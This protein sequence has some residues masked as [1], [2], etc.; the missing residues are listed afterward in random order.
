MATYKEMYFHLFAMTE[1]A[2]DALLV[3]DYKLAYDVLCTAQQ[4]CEEMYLENDDPL[5]TEII[6]FPENPPKED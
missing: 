4:E 3:D 5:I 6:P 1:Y 2:I